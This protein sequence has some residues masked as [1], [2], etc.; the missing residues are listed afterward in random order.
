MTKFLFYFILQKQAIDNSRDGIISQYREG[1]GFMDEYGKV[2]ADKKNIRKKN[3]L[4]FWGNHYNFFVFK[5]LLIKIELQTG[6]VV[7]RP[8]PGSF[9]GYFQLLIPLHTNI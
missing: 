3:I 1:N 4:M 5:Y 7:K 6:L 8:N 9:F 2:K